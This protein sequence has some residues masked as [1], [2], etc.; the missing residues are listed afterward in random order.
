M[1]NDSLIIS[2]L[3]IL[4]VGHYENVHL[5]QNRCISASFCSA[6]YLLKDNTCIGIKH[7]LC[8]NFRHVPSD[9][10]KLNGAL[11]YVFKVMGQE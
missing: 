3:N 1:V 5:R 7:V 10:L 4:L 9:V 11:L 8:F 6:H 2:A